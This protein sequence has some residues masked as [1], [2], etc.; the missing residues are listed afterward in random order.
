MPELLI[1]AR[2]ANDEWGGKD[3]GWLVRRC[4]ILKDERRVEQQHCC[5]TMA[6]QANHRC[7]EHPGGL[8][9]PDLFVYYSPAFREYGIVNHIEGEIA[10]IAFC[11]WC[12]C[13]LPESLRSRW[14]EELAARGI[15]PWEDGVPEIFRSAAWWAGGPTSQ[16]TV[17][18]DGRRKEG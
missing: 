2:A 3:G 12:G 1:G 18:R 17:G 10:V 7:D 11:P 4:W 15:D 5:P 13:Q 8:E 14:S 16:G 6:R 9:C